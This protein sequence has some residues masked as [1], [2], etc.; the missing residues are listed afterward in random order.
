MKSFAE[1]YADYINAIKLNSLE[2]SNRVVNTPKMTIYYG[3]EL[4]ASTFD[5]G[6]LKGLASSQPETV[7]HIA[8]IPIANELLSN[9]ANLPPQV[10]DLI[11]LIKR[12]FTTNTQP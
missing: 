1:T 8:T 5:I 12:I 7:Q 6:L 2:T 3:S 11:N 4:M 10:I 9:Q